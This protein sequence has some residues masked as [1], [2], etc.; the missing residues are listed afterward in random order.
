MQKRHLL[1][2]LPLCFFLLF[3]GCTN[4]LSVLPDHSGYVSDIPTP[5]PTLDEFAMNIFLTDVTTDTISLRYSLSQPENYGIS[6]YP[7]TLGSIEDALVP[8]KNALNLSFS[9]SHTN[10]P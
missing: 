8:D 5:T 6:D 10:L 1:H 2:T 9:E 3:A 7:I 4:Q